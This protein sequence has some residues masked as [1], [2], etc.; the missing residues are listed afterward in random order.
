MVAGESPDAEEDVE[1]EEAEDG[2]GY[3]LGYE[4]D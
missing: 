3:D 2:E 4:A 1:C